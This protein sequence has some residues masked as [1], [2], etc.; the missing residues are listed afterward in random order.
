MLLQV[1]CFSFSAVTACTYDWLTDGR[2]LIKSKLNR[3]INNVC[4]QVRSITKKAKHGTWSTWYMKIIWTVQY[5]FLMPKWTDLRDCTTRPHSHVTAILTFHIIK[6]SIFCLIVLRLLLLIHVVCVQDLLEKNYA[7]FSFGL[8]W[9][10][11]V[12]K[13]YLLS[14]FLPSVDIYVIKLLWVIAINFVESFVFVQSLFSRKKSPEVANLPLPDETFCLSFWLH[15]QDK[16]LFQFPKLSSYIT[17]QPK[18]VRYFGNTLKPLTEIT[19][20]S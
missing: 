6:D 17:H 13:A 19:F 16:W 5:S 12:K 15:K 9:F 2:S 3:L 14:I 8:F 11:S 18:A 7:E 1:Y 4:F 20:S 10:G